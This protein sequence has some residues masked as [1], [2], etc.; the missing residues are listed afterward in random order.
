MASGAR[1][2]EKRPT[3]GSSTKV[4]GAAT[5]SRVATLIRR[6]GEVAVRGKLR[7]LT[8]PCVGALWKPVQQKHS[9]GT[10]I[11]S[12]IDTSNCMPATWICTEWIP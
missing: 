4:Y 8:T 11:A 3:P 1:S 2:V 9:L 10:R 7:Q 12:R 5:E 6:D